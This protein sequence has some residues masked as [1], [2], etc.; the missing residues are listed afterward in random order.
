MVLKEINAEPETKVRKDTEVRRFQK[1]PVPTQ[2]KGDIVYCTFLCCKIAIGQQ[3][4][5]EEL[6]RPGIR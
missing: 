6:D 5:Q 1:N 2:W 4:H 3:K